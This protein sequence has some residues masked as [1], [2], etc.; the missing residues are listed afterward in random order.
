MKIY[1]IHLDMTNVLARLTNY[2]LK[3]FNHEYPMIFVEAEDP[4]GACYACSCKFTEVLLKHDYSKH[5]A[6]FIK[7]ITRDIRITKVY[8]KDEKKL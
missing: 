6:L 3:Q 1:V 2:N 7:E 4:D 5:N 8:C